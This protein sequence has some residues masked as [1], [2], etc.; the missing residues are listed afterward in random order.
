MKAWGHFCT[1]QHHRHLVM[2]GCFRVGLYKQ[3]LL[4]DLSKY[5]P[6][7]FLVGCKYYQGDKSPNNVERERNGCSWR[8]CTIKGAISIPGIL[9]RLWPGRAEESNRHENADQI[10]G[11]D[12]H[13]PYERF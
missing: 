6:V 9:D 2:R 3:G 4:H 12:V 7:E 11:G 13:R 1:I 10:C 5:S 8:G